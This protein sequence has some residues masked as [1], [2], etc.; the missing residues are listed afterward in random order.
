MVIGPVLKL[1]KVAPQ[2]PRGSRDRLERTRSHPLPSPCS[3][4]KAAQKPANGL[5]DN[6]E[7]RAPENADRAVRLRGR[8]IPSPAPTRSQCLFQCLAP[9]CL[10]D[11]GKPIWVAI[12]NRIP[13]RPAEYPQGGLNPESRSE[14]IA[15]SKAALASRASR[16]A[17]AD[18]TSQPLHSL[19]T[20]AI[21]AET[22]FVVMFGSRREPMELLKCADCVL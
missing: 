6:L 15:R 2:R 8:L 19:D 11:L 20:P 9:P 18:G 3:L 21:G 16:I 5:S 1:W 10:D 13:L 4:L 12:R 7:A 17:S 14:A 22:R